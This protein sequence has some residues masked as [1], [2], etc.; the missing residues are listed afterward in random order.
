[1]R[2]R[3]QR[4]VLFDHNTTLSSQG[5]DVI[6]A[7]NLGEANEAEAIHVNQA[8]NVGVG[9]PSPVTK[10]EVGG[11]LALD[12]ADAGPARVLP[13]AATM[14][15]ND[16]TWLR[17]NQN[18]DMSKPVFGVHTPGVLSSQSVNVGG[19]GPGGWADPGPGRATFAGNV[20][21]GAFAMPDRLHVDGTMRCTGSAV[22]N[23]D[24]VVNRDLVVNRNA[25]V[26]RDAIINQDLIVNQ[27]IWADKNINC[28]G[29]KF[30]VIPHPGKATIELPEYFEALTRP[31]GRTVQLT[32]MLDEDGGD[33][34][35]VSALAATRVNKG[36]FVVRQIGKGSPSQRFWWEV[37][38]VRADV[39]PLEPEVDASAIRRPSRPTGADR[40]SE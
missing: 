15:W 34:D 1:M 38:A 10:L 28:G 36:R 30:F 19:L 29:I 24:V 40:D 17:L 22:F 39:A 32:P 3:R 9:V 11:D 7:V 6:V 4:L 18:R 26:N 31:D 8:A 25:V 33:E 2:D 21:I 14:I 5:G 27:D 35:T 20:A 37:K 16:G 23:T 13:P 12:K